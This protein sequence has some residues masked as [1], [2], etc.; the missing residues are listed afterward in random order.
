MKRIEI[1]ALQKDKK[2]LLSLLQQRGLME[3]SVE[4]QREHTF[5]EDTAQK[6]GEYQ[7]GIS[8]IKNA[9]ETL[10]PYCEEKNG[11]LS[12]LA[13]RKKLKKEEFEKFEA[14]LPKVLNEAKEV[15][16]LE[17][18][19]AEGKAGRV[20]L[21][22]NI[23]ALEPFIDLDVPVTPKEGGKYSY[24]VGSL[25]GE[26]TLT[27]ILTLL[28][29]ADSETELH[30]EVLS[31]SKAKTGIFVLCEK[32]KEKQAE[33][34]LRA[35]GFEYPNFSATGV[36]TEEIKNIEKKQEE[37]LKKEEEYLK[38]LKELAGNTDRFEFAQDI[39]TMKLDKAQALASLNQT[40]HALFISGYIPEKYADKVLS[41][42]NEKF[43]LYA[44]S[45]T[46]EEDEDV[47]VALENNGFSAPV[48]GVLNAFGLPAKG[49]IDP[50]G[51]MSIFYYVL[52]G[53][54]FSDAGYGLIMMIACG[55]VWAKYR[56]SDAPIIQSVK[57]FFWCGLSTA[58]WGFVFGSF[59][60]DVLEVVSQN[61][62]NASWKTP[63]WWFAPLKDPMKMLIFTF[64]LGIIHMFTGLALSGYQ[65]LKARQVKDFF[66]DVVAWFVL[67]IA[68][69]FM[70]MGSSIFE[71]IAGFKLN[72][73]PW[74]TT[75]INGAALLGAAV[76]ILTAGRESRNWF[77]RI[78]KGL[79]GLYGAT[80]WLGDVISYSRL[81]ALGLATGVVGSVVNQM[82]AML[83]NIFAFI[84]VFL[85]GHTLN[86]A[87]NVLGAYVH[88]NRLQ[89]VEFFGKFYE[90]GGKEFKPLKINTKN[91]TIMEDK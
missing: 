57:M 14:E 39:L 91:Y 32:A 41:E 53:L 3:I 10:K 11:M 13:G 21:S 73:Q 86:F 84:L 2:E 79:Y 68:L 74:H 76:I 15:A 38:R 1:C 46:P 9:L 50:V 4:Q 20:K 54:M 43:E 26:F 49:E 70:L 25:P 42:L 22:A 37:S 77:K 16:E 63:T 52:F 30:V 45:F 83:G 58:L 88:C 89:F 61:F 71:G 5:K 59:F 29:K 33:S 69:I 12:S 7:K 90:G 44:Q 47:P 31:I 80:G 72:Y 64:V 35:I 87:I 48:T 18:A 34:A 28:A 40:E 51:I 81:L 82:G 19:I 56:K 78:L 67:L 62:F 8:E 23:A 36:P 66:F 85:I 65:K 27:D 55:I 17:R 60:G 75:L 24:F 6:C